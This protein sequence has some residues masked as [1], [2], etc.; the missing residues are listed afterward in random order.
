MPAKPANKN[1]IPGWLHL[2]TRL[3]LGLLIAAAVVGGLIWAGRWSMEQLHG[4][5]RY[6]VKFTDI[7]CEP[8]A[9]MSRRDF[10]D[11]VLYESQL[12]AQFDLTDINLRPQLEEGFARHRWVEKVMA[13]EIR[14]PNQI[15]VKL[16]YR[17]K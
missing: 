2:G 7:I 11:E 5:G 9:G 15:E 8:P 12:P 17:K 4:R 1:A 6:V 16:V 3:L 14:Q 13:V 10:L